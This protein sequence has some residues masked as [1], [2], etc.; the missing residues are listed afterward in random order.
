[1]SSNKQNIQK[2]L[3]SYSALAGTIV[4][5]VS[6]ADAQ[7][8]YTDVMPDST[9]NNGGVY[10]LD[11]NNDDVADFQLIQHSGTYG[12]L[13]SYDVVGVYALGANN[14][15]D[16]SGGNGTAT[17]MDAGVTIDATLHWVDSTE[18][19]AISP[20]TANALAAVIPMFGIAAGNF[21]DS[22]NKYLPLRFSNL[23]STYYGWVRLDVAADAKSFVVKDYAYTDDPDHYTVTGDMV[24]ISEAALLNKINI[25]AYNNSITVQLDP[26]VE[27]EGKIMIT[28]LSGQ[29]VSE[30][31]I[32]STE[33][34]IPFEQAKPGIYMVTVKQTHGSYTK[35]VFVK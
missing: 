14:A 6:S 9:V 33:T 19:A 20:P 15:V 1:M 16:T 34:V 31:A 28:S 30:T 11:L 27:A 2:K 10:N 21:I 7:V 18:M 24:G 4:A 29:A 8:V 5:A 12:G 22:T 35:R 13:A 23:G 17:A 26:L 25:F 32:N 3:K